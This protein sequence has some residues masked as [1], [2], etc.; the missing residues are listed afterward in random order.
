MPSSQA[1]NVPPVIRMCRFLE[2]SCRTCFV[3]PQCLCLD[4]PQYPIYWGPERSE[5]EDHGVS[6]LRVIWL[7]LAVYQAAGNTHRNRPFDIPVAAG[8]HHRSS[9]RHLVP[10]SCATPVAKGG[11]TPCI[12]EVFK[13][14]VL[15]LNIWQCLHHL[16]TAFSAK[17]TF[18]MSLG[19][20]AYMQLCTLTMARHQRIFS[21]PPTA[22]RSTRLPSSTRRS[23]CLQ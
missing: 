9:S 14:R 23:S 6:C 7:R 3:Y 12:N 13:L 16:R 20:P 10:H 2:C 4:L 5:W 8:V 11:D 15:P 21:S 1:M 18:P 17:A 22:L 19:C